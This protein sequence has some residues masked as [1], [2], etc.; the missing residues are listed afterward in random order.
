MKRNKGMIIL[1]L[2]PAVLMFSVIF[3]YPIVRTVIMS[4]FKIDGITDPVSKWQFTGLANF[5]KLANTSLFRISMWNLLRIWFIGGI[6]VMSLALLFAVIIT[7][8][9]RFKSFFRAVIYL[10]NIVSA[11]ALATMWLQYVYSP[12]FGLLKTV[13]SGLGLD[14]LAKVQWLDN[15]HKIGR[16]SGRERVYAP[17]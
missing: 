17:V 9:I 4:F 2:T 16:A 10:P 14:S 12:K 5:T 13:F 6:V 1:F 11:V 8:G 15:D 7:S 3:L